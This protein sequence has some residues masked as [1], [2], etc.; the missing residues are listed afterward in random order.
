M[1]RTTEERSLSV[2][3]YVLALGGVLWTGLEVMATGITPIILYVAGVPCAAIVAV[4]WNRSRFVV[5][6][7]LHALTLLVIVRVAAAVPGVLLTLNLISTD[8][9]QINQYRVTPSFRIGGA[10]FLFV[11]LP[12]AFM[13]WH[14]L[15]EASGGYFFRWPLLNW[16]KAKFVPEDRL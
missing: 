10:I 15:T 2:I 13:A 7:G 5:A 14:S 11:V 1:Q 3:A 6:H 4:Y 8:A 12:L 9:V 16:Y